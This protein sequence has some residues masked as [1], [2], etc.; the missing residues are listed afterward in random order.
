M[1]DLRSLFAG[2]VVST[3]KNGIM[4][5]DTKEVMRTEH[6]QFVGDSGAYDPETLKNMSM[7]WE[8]DKLLIVPLFD[9]HVGGEGFEADR[10]KMVLDFIYN[11]KIAR[12]FF[13]GDMFDNAN[14]AG[15]T[16]P[17][18]SRLNPSKQFDYL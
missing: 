14:L 10:F 11:C 1:T 5:D 12:T 6:N 9:S 8:E 18:L 2:A 7:F 13:G 3:Y 15:K 4:T 16:N 17:L